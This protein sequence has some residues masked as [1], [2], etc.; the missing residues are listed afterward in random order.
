MINRIKLIIERA[1]ARIKYREDFRRHSWHLKG[2]KAGWIS[3][4]FCHTHEGDP[5]MSDEEYEEWD[6]DGD[7]CMFVCKVL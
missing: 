2:V 1:T 4:V 5:Y 3:P 7:P 6:T